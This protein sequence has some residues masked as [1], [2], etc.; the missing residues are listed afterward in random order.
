G[1]HISFDLA[2]GL[3]TSLTEAERIKALCGTLEPGMDADETPILFA[4]IGEPGLRLSEVATS[5]VREI[6]RGRVRG[7]L[8]QVA[9]RLERAGI[10][11][12]ATERVV[13]TGGAGQLPGLSASAGAFFGKS[14][15]I[16]Q[17]EAAYGWP[18]GAAGPAF[19]TVLGVAQVAFDPA[20]GVRRAERS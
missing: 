6:V 14:V 17:P 19:S 15:R 9:E 1:H 5:K 20:A 18:A 3:T 13:V 11:E 12:G 8:G 2:R 16:G 10:T 4:P 7:I